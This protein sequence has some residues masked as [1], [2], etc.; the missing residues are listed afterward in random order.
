MATL[1]HTIDINQPAEHVFWYSSD[2][3][4][5]VDW[6]PDITSVERVTDGPVGLGTRYRA[7]WAQGGPTIVEYVRFE[8]PV[9][10]AATATSDRLTINFHAWVAPIAEGARLAVRMELVPH[11]VTPRLA[12]PILRRVMKRAEERNVV[13]IKAKLESAGTREARS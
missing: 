2:L 12:W 11:G 7:Q 3:C 6:N 4:N 5:E 13:A 10:W 9:H 8:P 1:Y